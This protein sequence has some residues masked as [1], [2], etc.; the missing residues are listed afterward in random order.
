[1]IEIALTFLTDLIATLPLLIPLI[2]VIN[3][4]SDLLFGK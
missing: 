4:V 3:L 1:M 2:L